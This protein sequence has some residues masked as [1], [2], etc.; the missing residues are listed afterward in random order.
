M[1]AF[2]CCNCQKKVSWKKALWVN[3]STKITCNHCGF[4]NK[5]M[6]SQYQKIGAIFGAFSGPLAVFIA[7]P[8][9]YNHK[10]IL[11]IGIVIAVALVLFSLLAMFLY[12]KLKFIP[13]H[14]TE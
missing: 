5:P 7:L 6:Q 9:F 8:L 14:Q 4:T 10:I 2:T 11:G 13:A 12:N 1:E 3:L